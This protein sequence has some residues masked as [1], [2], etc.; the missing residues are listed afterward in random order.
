MKSCF[1]SILLFLICSCGSNQSAST[2][3]QSRNTIVINNKDCQS[4]AF[5]Y[6]ESKFPLSGERDLVYKPRRS[7]DGRWYTITLS[8]T[9][10]NNHYN[11]IYNTF[12]VE[13]DENCK[14][15]SLRKRM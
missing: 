13:V 8:I 14:L 5:S 3:K 11:K 4:Q 9:D 10:P 12:T 6:V 15:I 2:N 1:F 7:K